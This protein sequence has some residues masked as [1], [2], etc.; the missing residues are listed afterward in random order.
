M[1]HK[2]QIKAPSVTRYKVKKASYLLMNWTRL[3]FLLSF[4]Q[5][6]RGRE[7]FMVNLP[8]LHFYCYQFEFGQC[9]FF[10]AKQ[11]FLFL[12]ICLAKSLLD[13][14]FS[15]N[16]QLILVQLGKNMIV[17]CQKDCLSKGRILALTTFDLVMAPDLERRAL[18]VHLTHLPINWKSLVP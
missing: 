8:F 13:L 12:V 18:F 15:V 7:Y 3:L 14:T 10:S 1:L 5:L 6:S 9:V 4:V 2:I 16:F 17:T 11:N